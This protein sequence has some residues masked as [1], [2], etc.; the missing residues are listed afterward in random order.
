MAEPIHHQI[1]PALFSSKSFNFWSF[2]SAQK[3]LCAQ[4]KIIVTNNT[5][6]YADRSNDKRK[7]NRVYLDLKVRV[8]PLLLNEKEN[9]WEIPS[10]VHWARGWDISESGIRLF[11]P[12]D[13][14]ECHYLT[15]SFRFHRK[16]T[17]HRA[18]LKKIW[19]RGNSAGFRF[20]GIS[21]EDRESVRQYVQAQK[22]LDL[23]L[24]AS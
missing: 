21:P 19:A 1:Q 22:K 17:D 2:I 8:A 15:V 24:V 11:L 10:P 18:F 20:L 6:N 3:K 12:P 23:P 7:Y 5:L 14:Q 13:L 16:E 4:E 9:N